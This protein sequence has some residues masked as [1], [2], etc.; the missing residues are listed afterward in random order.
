MHPTHSDSDEDLPTLRG[1]RL[2]LRPAGAEDVESL[3]EIL[4]EPEVARW[5]GSYDIARVR[6]ELPGT[7]AIVIEDALAGWLHVHGERG[8]HFPSVALD[9]LLGTKLH[10]RGHGREAL[11]L[12]IDHFIKSGHHRFTIDPAVDNERAI[13]SYKALGFKGVGVMR[14][15]ER[16]PDGSWRDGL[17]MDLLASEFNG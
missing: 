9:I 8:E 15:Y 12:A 10:G 16:T 2:L 7:Y 11:K 4:T 6:E 3:L 13:R 17:L 1:E 5:W 14:A